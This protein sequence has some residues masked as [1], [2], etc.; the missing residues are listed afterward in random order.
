MSWRIT[1]LFAAGLFLVGLAACETLGPDSNSSPDSERSHAKQVELN[2]TI[3]DDVSCIDG[4]KTDW[5]FFSVPSPT[6][7]AVTFAFD[8]PSAG[9]TV[10]IHQ[11]T[12]EIM[13][14]VKSIPNSRATQEF[15]AVRGHYYLE[16]Y[17]QAYKSEYTLEVTTSQ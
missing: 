2:R 5:K 8:E 17:C 4:D 11:P 9:G 6:R 14:V 1:A 3:I 16:I 10:V 7:I 15:D 13:K 12:G